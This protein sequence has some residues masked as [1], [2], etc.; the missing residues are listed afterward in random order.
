MSLA[1]VA[2]HIAY[3]EGL[4]QSSGSLSQGTDSVDAVIG[5][6]TSKNSTLEDAGFDNGYGDITAIIPTADV[7]DWT[8][9]RDT[10]VGLVAEH[11]SGSLVI[12]DPIRYVGPYTWLNLDRKR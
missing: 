7:A 6:L 11:Y 10:E 5:Y 3:K 9:S 8:I 2:L 4:K 12:R 1:D